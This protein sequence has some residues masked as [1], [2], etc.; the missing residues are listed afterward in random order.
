[1][2][3]LAPLEWSLMIMFPISLIVLFSVMF[4]WQSTPQFP[5]I[6]TFTRPKWSNWKWL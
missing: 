1:M 3:H 2:P 4:W 5:Q 6:Y